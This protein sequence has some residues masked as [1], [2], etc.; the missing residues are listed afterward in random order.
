MPCHCSHVNIHEGRRYKPIALE[1]RNQ[2]S[3]SWSHCETTTR[4][5]ASSP[6]RWSYPIPIRFL[7]EK[8]CTSSWLGV[9]TAS[10]TR[11]TTAYGSAHSAVQRQLLAVCCPSYRFCNLAQQADG[12]ICI[13]ASP[14]PRKTK[15]ATPTFRVGCESDHVSAGNRPSPM[16]S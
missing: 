12:S 8:L 11:S 13:N 4:I 1:G 2:P 7:L 16:A 14:V 3:H 5:H 9:P 15:P 6:A 10:F